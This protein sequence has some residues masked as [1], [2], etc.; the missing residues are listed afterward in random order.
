MKEMRA[1]KET[2]QRN[3]ETLDMEQKEVSEVGSIRLLH[4]RRNS[5]VKHPWILRLQR[6]LQQK[7]NKEEEEEEEQ[8]R[9]RSRGRLKKKKTRAKVEDDERRGESSICKFQFL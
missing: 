4:R 6:D 8:R 2:Y 1:R 5:R 3:G 9:R 7:K